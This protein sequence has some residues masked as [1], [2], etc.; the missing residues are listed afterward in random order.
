MK[1]ESISS[2]N[3]LR[4]KHLVDFLLSTFGSNSP[5]KPS[6]DAITS[7]DRDD[8][9]KDNGPIPFVQ[10]GSPNDLATASDTTLR[11]DSF[12]TTRASPEDG[13]NG[14]IP[15]NG[16]LTLSI[17][18][19]TSFFDQNPSIVNFFGLEAENLENFL[20]EVQSF[21]SDG[22]ADEAIINNKNFLETEFL[23]S[24][25]I[26]DQEIMDEIIYNLY[27]FQE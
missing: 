5:N 3:S 11:L 22:T 24:K 14:D 8:L 27:G 7:I 10:H 1:G 21:S 17:E 6:Q 19:Q 18:N 26:D 12:D 16:N 9:S 25:N 4:P 15:S 20:L 2:S 23:H 13:N